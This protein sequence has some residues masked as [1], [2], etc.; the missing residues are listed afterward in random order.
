MAFLC[1]V[2]LGCFPLNVIYTVYLYVQYVLSK[3]YRLCKGHIFFLQTYLLSDEK[4]F[5]ADS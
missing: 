5:C 2:C 1:F 3:Y 4:H